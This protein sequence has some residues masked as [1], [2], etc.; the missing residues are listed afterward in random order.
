VR[1][2][3]ADKAGGNPVV[4]SVTDFRIRRLEARP[5]AHEGAFRSMQERT[6]R[7]MAESKQAVDR[8][9]QALGEV[10]NTSQVSVN[11]RVLWKLEAKKK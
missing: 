2:G 10:R 4:N 11:R 5:E 8:A 6:A 1:Q 3:N 7:I 9:R